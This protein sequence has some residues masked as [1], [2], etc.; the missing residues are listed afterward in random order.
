V[1]FNF[2]ISASYPLLLLLL[3]LLP[4]FIWFQY[5][6]TFRITGGRKHTA[7]VL[8]SLILLLVICLVSDVQP[9]NSLKQRNV[10][11]LVDRSASVGGEQATLSFL[12]SLQ[13]DDERDHLAV[14]SFGKNIVV[15]SSLQ[16]LAGW[17][18]L[19]AFHTVVQEGESGIAAALRQGAGLLNQYSGGKIVLLTD[20]LETTG[21]FLKEVQ[22]LEAMDVTVDVIQLPHRVNRDAAI[23]ALKVPD[24]LKQ[25][26]KYQ[27]AV[28]ISSTH[29]GVAELMLYEDDALIAQQQLELVQGE[30]S[31][32]IDSVATSSGMKQYRAVVRME[33]DTEAKNNSSYGFSR[34]TGPAGV[35]I[36]EG[37][38]GSSRNIE[39]ALASSFIAYRTISPVELSYELASYV[40]YDAIIFNNVSAVD[41]PQ[42]KMEH[43]ESAVRH[44]GVGFV[45]LGG[46]DSFGLGG[47]F[48][49]PI[50]KI[51]PLN[52]Q[53]SGKKQIPDLQLML[54]ID[55]SGSMFGS[56]M[57][58][59]KEAAART[60]E[61]MR[62]VDM[63]GVI[64]FDSVPTWV[65]SPTKLEDKEDIIT[66]IMSI[67]PAGGTD[68]YPALSA[69]YEGFDLSAGARKHMILL[70]DGI[71]PYTPQYEE[72]LNNLKSNNITL[73]T[74]AVGQD[75]DVNF[76]QDLAESGGGRSY[77]A[78]DESTLPAIFSREATLMSRAYIVEGTI[79]PIEGYAGSWAQ[80]WRDGL[81]QLDAYVAT[82][83]KSTAEV[84]L[85]SPQEDPI[86]AR[87]NIGAGKSVAFTSDVNGK[88]SSDWVSWSKFP[89]VFTEW[90]R[91]TYPQFVQTPYSIEQDGDGKLTIISN[92]E[93]SQSNLGLTIN[94][95]SQS[96]VVPLVPVASGQYEA[97]V[98][99][100]E[101]GVYFT[102]IGELQQDGSEGVQ[103]GVT[104]AFVV[105]Y[106]AE[107]R[108][109][110][111]VQQA[112]EKLQTLTEMTGGRLLTLEQ[113]NELF[114]F[115]PTLQQKR[116]N[117][118]KAL[119]LLL[120]LFWLLD[121]ANRRLSLPWRNWYNRLVGSRSSVTATGAGTA[122][123][124]ANG[125]SSSSASLQRLKQRKMSVSERSKFMP[126][127]AGD[128]I[129]D[130]NSARASAPSTAGDGSSSLASSSGSASSANSTSSTSSAV[131]NIPVRNIPTNGSKSAIAPTNK[132][133][134]AL[135]ANNNGDQQAAANKS[136][137]TMNRLLAAKNRKK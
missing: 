22:L 118:S 109:D 126:R 8:R 92:A 110:V 63:V 14:I 44:Y 116:D 64:A 21:S 129:K 42:V 137:D 83:P 66:S 88:W 67:Q 77:F 121:I 119:L 6:Y 46:N 53:L 87:W 54:A 58:L 25:G 133:D 91:W 97:D 1:G 43:I 16:P 33:G 7:V 30:N 19:S 62:P 73:S 105:P 26:E 3:L 48:D 82:S 114:D 80:L 90:V 57:E 47:Y 108:L 59:A 9:Y 99:Q 93:A 11:V 130:V 123:A 111:D 71:S 75:S 85:W 115:E 112:T 122:E 61:L 113:G 52:M 24:Q 13:S 81:P 29:Q 136:N 89:Q 68:I 49:T 106:S 40:Q 31:Y 37:E 98:S 86:L 38:A 125:A 74:V 15:D 103:N 17:N 23:S 94:E 120:L 107:Y 84:A 2:G 10:A 35:L 65:V 55:H 76:L 100:L 96:E 45:M 20:G 131:P 102:Q 56:K 95:G 32:L 41:L 34:V 36:V 127:E 28:T 104:T 70:T 132:F 4:P 117:W 12:Q 51:L 5:Q 128:D 72:L 60:V 79:T 18:P 124:G 78:Q 50:E 134:E 69:A 101:S 39:A 135:K 27:I